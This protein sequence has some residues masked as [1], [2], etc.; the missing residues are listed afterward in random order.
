MS[1]L[2]NIDTTIRKRGPPRKASIPEFPNDIF[3]FPEFPNQKKRF[4]E[5]PNAIS[6]FPELQAK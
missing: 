6:D 2:H 4:P 5:F 1:K 3:H